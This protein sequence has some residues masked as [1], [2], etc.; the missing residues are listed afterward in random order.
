LLGGGEEGE[1]GEEDAGIFSTAALEI[2][3]AALVFGP[4]PFDA[5]PLVPPPFAAGFE[6]DAAAEIFA[7][8]AANFEAAAV[9]P[10]GAPTAFAGLAGTF[11]GMLRSPARL[12]SRSCRIQSVTM[13]FFLF[14]FHFLQNQRALNTKLEKGCTHSSAH[15]THTHTHILTHTYTHTNTQSETH[16]HTQPP[17]MTP[18]REGDSHSQ[19]E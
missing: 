7:P 10:V 5:P 19:G 11:G 9:M 14:F 12:V 13:T 8:A 4:P 16:R 1:T 3:V 2:V 18:A 6:E 15:T 17:G